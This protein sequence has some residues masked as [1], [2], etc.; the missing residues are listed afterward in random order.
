[1]ISL[2]RTG[3]NTLIAFLRIRNYGRT[4]AIVVAQKAELQISRHG[5][6]PPT[7]AFFDSSDPITPY[8]FPQDIAHPMLAQLAT[9]I[10]SDDRALMDNQAIFVWLCGYIRYK[11]SVPRK[12][13]IEYETR[14]C[15]V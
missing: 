15:Y 8:V 4:P 3:T 12:D 2:Q 13:A 7:P 14:F 5:L 9:N 6:K 11:D 1:M 10:T